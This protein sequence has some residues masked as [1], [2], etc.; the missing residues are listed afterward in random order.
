MEAS[1]DSSQ[2]ANLKRS[3]VDQ[4]P[5]TQANMRSNVYVKCE[6]RDAVTESEGCRGSQ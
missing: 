4:Q 2:A 6:T 1:S 5:F 3:L